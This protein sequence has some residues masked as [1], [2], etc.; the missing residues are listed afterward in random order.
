MWDVKQLRVQGNVPE[1]FCARVEKKGFKFV[2]LVTREAV[3]ACEFHV[4]ATGEE[5]WEC[6][7]ALRGIGV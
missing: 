6:S 7:G 2:N 4:H 1:A 5:R 3:K